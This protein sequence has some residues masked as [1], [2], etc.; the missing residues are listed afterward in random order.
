MMKSN[1]MILVRSN[2]QML[3][4][5]MRYSKRKKKFIPLTAIVLLGG[6][7]MVALMAFTAVVQTQA[8][9]E[10]GHPEYAIYYTV[11]QTMII[12]LL[13]A[14]MRGGT[15]TTSTDANFLLSLPVKR[16][17]IQIS[18]SIS[19]YVFDLLPIIVIMLPAVVVYQVMIGTVPILLRS[20]LTMLMIPLCSVGLAYIISFLLFKASNRFRRPEYIRT[21]LILAVTVLFMVFIIGMSGSMGM[22]GD[23]P[24]FISK[25][26]PLAWG[27]DFAAYGG[28]RN[29]GLFALV[30]VVPFVIGIWLQSRVY[31][32]K[33]TNWR[34]KKTTL[35]FKEKSPTRALFGKE[36]RQ[37]F[38]IPIYVVNTILGP[39]FAVAVVVALIFAR[40]V[41]MEFLE[42]TPEFAGLSGYMNITIL[43]MMLCFS[44]MTM[45]SASSI[46]L[47][48]KNIRILRAAPVAEKDVFKSKILVHLALTVVPFALCTVAAGVI[49][50]MDVLTI[51][52]MTL[53]VTVATVLIAF[54][55]LYVNLLVP[56]LNWDN[57]MVVVKQ[58][59]SVGVSIAA[60]FIIA[61]IP[62]IL[63]VILGKNFVLSAG[64]S[65]ALIVALAVVVWVLLK[66]DGVK[67]YREL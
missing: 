56:K 15:S 4:G 30:S 64:V 31:G 52:L 53:V 18:K 6:A 49:L 36:L 24:T 67:R 11:A 22:G 25:V 39:V 66:T 42:A 1:L 5:S 57:E 8:F 38:S 27:A 3:W 65:L 50:Q 26:P 21:I 37:Y 13:L 59:A 45:I 54:T 55:G 61:L 43:S 33:Q 62:L 2:M 40:N 58:S 46:S 41:L 17:T 16:S 19:R 48:G 10:Q 47:E 32:V 20:I 60:G 29:F 14:V 23:L 51:A 34:S 9:G 28:I 12:V 63:F 7:V 35:D 44:A